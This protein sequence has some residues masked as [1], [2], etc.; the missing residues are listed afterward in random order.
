MVPYITLRA[1]LNAYARYCSKVTSEQKATLICDLKKYIDKS[2]WT[3]YDIVKDSRT[4][5]MLAIQDR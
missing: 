1:L 3:D 2:Q 5:W 4:L